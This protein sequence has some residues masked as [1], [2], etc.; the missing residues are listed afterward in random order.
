MRFP[1]NRSSTFVYCYYCTLDKVKN[2]SC[3]INFQLDMSA[4]KKGASCG[5]KASCTV[6][7]FWLV[8]GLVV[9]V[10]LK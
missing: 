3:L 8:I 5:Q 7:D 9:K 6:N 2:F 4:A 1:Y 10:R